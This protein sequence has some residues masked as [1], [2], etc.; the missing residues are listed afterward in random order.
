MKSYTKILLSAFLL[1]CTITAYGQVTNLTVNGATSNF[2][3]VSGS[4]I[5]WTYNVPAGSTALGE[6]WY[7]VNGSGTIDAGDV[8]Y[9][10]FDQTDGD[11]Q[12][13]NGPPDMDGKANG[14]IT[15]SMPAGIAPGKYVFRFTEGGSSATIA[16]TATPL[17]SPAYTIQGT[18]TAPAGKSAANIFVE[19]KR[20][21]KYQPNFWD[22][23]TDANGNYSIAMNSDTA[24]N[25]WRI[26]L[27]SNP[28]PPNIINPAEYD[29]TISGSLTGK[30][31]SFASAAAQ[32]AGTVKDENGNAMANA[33]VS[34]NS[35]SSIS[36]VNIDV[37]TNS[38]GVYQIG[39]TQADLSQSSQAWTLESYFE[40]PNGYTTTQLD[41]RAFVQTISPGDSI[42]RNFVIYNA[43]STISGTVTLNGMAPGFPI[44]FAAVS[45]DS[46]QSTTVSASNG[47]FSFPVSNKIYSYDIYFYN[48]S[49]IFYM[50]NVTAHPGQ[51]NVQV[52]LS[53]SPLG[54]K[55]V[56]NNAPKAF[57]L[58]QNYPNP[59]NPATNI[60]YS[61]PKSGYVTLKV[62]NELGNE[63]ETLYNGNQNAG[64]YNVTFN[65]AKLA[66]GI[67]YY[68]LRSGNLISTK[69]MILL[70]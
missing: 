69:K 60:Q 26:S 3:M 53:T 18:I 41:G 47:T 34:I 67:Y 10:A 52:I 49:Q 12:G 40:G 43:N 30:N 7:D 16:G 29:V 2:T 6:I 51:T 31:F 44:S 5:S 46:A 35:Y 9:Q 62:Y 65:A 63:V 32:V 14:V 20:S 33:S 59:F 56:S 45:P 22:A 1:F 64:I 36:P 17:P 25:P 27:I 48:S 38:S 55:Q 37:K 42:V 61:V 39:L 24:G 28:F 13:H 8:L 68:Q 50:N 57:S 66:S 58:E 54:I 19:L 21:E 4:N 23:V 70:K 15:F 11:T